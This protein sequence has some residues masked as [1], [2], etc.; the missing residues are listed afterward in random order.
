M[1]SIP[2]DKSCQTSA[3]DL[4]SMLVALRQFTTEKRKELGLAW[5]ETLPSN[6][7]FA[8]LVRRAA[9]ATEEEQN[10][11]AGAD[12]RAAD[13]LAQS[14]SETIEA[15]LEPLCTFRD[16]RKRMLRKV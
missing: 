1:D 2:L 15:I 5:P 12:E 6:E 7:R 3:N 11:K 14:S 16:A 10:S 13:H 4:R 9:S 8:E